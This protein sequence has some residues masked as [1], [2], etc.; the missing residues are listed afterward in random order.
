MKIG[1]SIFNIRKGQEMTQEEFASIFAVTRQTVSNWE[2]EKSYPDLQ[3]LVDMSDQFAVSLDSMLKGNE[4]MVK[5]I[6]KERKFSKYVK[7][8][9]FLLGVL[10]LFFCAIWSIIWYDVKQKAEKRFQ[11]GVKQFS[12][13]DNSSENPDEEAYQYPYKLADNDGVT[14]F[15]TDL[16]MSEWFE[17]RYLGSY[18]QTLMCRVQR[19]NDLLQ[20]EWY[21][22]HADFLTIYTYDRTGKHVLTDQETKKLLR[23]DSQIQ[24]LNDKAHQICKAI[25]MDYKWSF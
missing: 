18:N 24:E 19:E 17:L 7:R 25:Y 21:G 11:D 14:F 12:F 6:D 5:K 1:E 22:E 23:D 9:G 2:K 16:L 4:D 13:Q 15:L 8:I 20:A 10:M 3:T